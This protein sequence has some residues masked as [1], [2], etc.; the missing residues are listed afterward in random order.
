MQTLEGE[1][2]QR[3]RGRAELGAAGDGAECPRSHQVHGAPSPRRASQG[4]AREA[5]RAQTEQGC[6]QVFAVA[7]DGDDLGVHGSD[8]EQQRGR[9]ARTDAGAEPSEP[10]PQARAH[11][12]VERDGHGVV[13]HGVE[14]EEAIA[15]HVEHDA[16]GP[17]HVGNVELRALRTEQKRPVRL[18][19]EAVGDQHPTVVVDQRVVEDREVQRRDEQQDAAQHGPRPELE[20]RGLELLEGRGL[21][22]DCP[23]ARASWAC[24]SLVFGASARNVSRRSRR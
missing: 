3:K 18:A 7:H 11:A 10:G 24:S 6:E 21:V 16:R 13:G 8:T 12:E 2:H 4:I 23:R 1:P 9:P 14:P 19:Q 5:H 17:K 22:H 20:Q 15:Q